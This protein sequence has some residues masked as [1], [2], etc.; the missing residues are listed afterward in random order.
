VLRVRRS[1]LGRTLRLAALAI[2]LGC[3]MYTAFNGTQAIFL[4]RAGPRAYPVFFVILALTVWPAIAALAAANRR[5]GVATAFRNNLLLNAFLPLPVY[6]AY[7]IAENYLVSFLAL[8][9]Y[10]VAFEILMLQ[11]W[12][13]VGRYFNIL[14][15]KRVFPVIAAG[16]GLG[17]IFAGAVTTLVVDR[18]GRPELLLFGW[19]LGAA[20]AWLIAGRAISRLHRPAPD[21]A[22]AFGDEQLETGP[23][24]TLASVREALRYLRVSRLVLA[25][26]LLGTVLLIGMR[27]SDY[28]VAIVF[29][30]STHDVAELTVLLGD[31]WM[32]SYVVQLALG[33]WLTP[34]LLA[35]AGVKNAILAL[36][37]ATVVGFA[38]VAL[39]PGL[40]TALFLFVVR[41]GLQTGVDDPARNVL[42]SALPEQVRPRLA[43][44]QDNLVLPGSAALTGVALLGIGFFFGS[45]SVLFLAGVGI[46]VSVTLLAMAIWVR[47]LYLSAVFQRLRSHTLSLADLELAIGRPSPEEVEELKGH[48][49]S[50]DPEVRRF[51]A[52]ALGSLAEDA[53]R[54]LAPGFLASD[55]PELRRLVFQLSPP[56]GVAAGLLDIGARDPD[57]WVA[58][59]A[60]VAGLEATAGWGRSREV[61]DELAR[62]DE[63]E[64]RAAAVWAA[65]FAGDERLIVEGLADPR[66]RVRLE[67]ISSFARLKGEDASAI[68]ALLPGLGDA[69]QEVRREAFRQ[70][71]RWAPPDDDGAAL[72]GVLLAG[73]ASPDPV[74]QRL[75]GEAISIQC[76]AAL[77]GA[78]DLLQGETRVA[79]AALEAIFR[80]GRTEPVARATAHLAEVLEAG[81]SSAADSRRAAL[82]D[83]WVLLRIALDDHSEQ[84]IAVG[85]AGLRSLHDK[86]GFSRVERGLRSADPGALAVATETLLN[87][88]PARLVEPLARLLDPESFEGRP[89]R[90]LSEAEIGRLA[91]HRDDWVRRAAETV[92]DAAQESMKDLIAL[93]KVPLFAN[94]TLQQLASID[95]LMVTR[96]YL[97]GEEIFKWGDHSSELYVV[98]E[99][100]VR[101]HRDDGDREV[102]LARLGPSSFMGEMAPFTEEPRSA[103]A[104]AVVATVVRVLRK[105]RLGAILHEHPEVLLEVIKNLSRRLVVA[106]SQLEAAVRSLTDPGPAEKAQGDRRRSR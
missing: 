31:A 38:A 10:S 87:F 58:A 62:S 28:L 19:A 73:L 29:V 99:G 24:G 37:L 83:R 54:E 61:L 22:E 11:F 44:L 85:L 100:E 105:D 82:D 77:D 53:F 55:D 98:L 8:V 74:T 42:D 101:I 66:P 86:R 51:A 76:P 94:L 5:W 104:E 90:P 49:A 32:L 6:A 35:R 71:L 2:V 92:R 59:A 81:L 47:S 78:L 79:V 63:A 106:N 16:S 67:A 39:A 15:A 46:A 40:A 68:E 45:A 50:D 69:D 34:W 84:A 13:F 23:V 96:P 80:C 36:P 26:V 57:P 52:A 75:A 41:N 18:T 27:V 60:A 88:G 1:E 43:T 17:Y 95:K 3:G 97:A 25:L 30:S 91:G 7:S 103:S 65:A 72:A 4:T 70:A 12:S 102:T 21:E 89:V 20:G 56:G 64:S 93:K 14:E 48:I 33:L 9:V